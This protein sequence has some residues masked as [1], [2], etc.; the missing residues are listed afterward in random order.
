MTDNHWFWLQETDAGL[1]S[2]ISYPAFSVDDP[3]LIKITRNGVIEKLQVRPLV[4]FC[5]YLLFE[6][7]LKPGANPIFPPPI[8]TDLIT[9]KFSSHFDGVWFAMLVFVMR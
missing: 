6:S 1:L 3:E 8:S 4:C 9:V 7:L 5:V 2:V